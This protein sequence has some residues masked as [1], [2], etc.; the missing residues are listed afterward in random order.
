MNCSSSALD[1]PLAAVCML[2]QKSL[3]PTSWLAIFGAPLF[4]DLGSRMLLRDTM[5][6]RPEDGGPTERLKRIQKELGRADRDGDLHR[7]GEAVESVCLADI[8]G[9]R[10]GTSPI[11]NHLTTWQ[12]LTD[13]N[14]ILLSS[15]PFRTL[16]QELKRRRSSN[17]PLSQASAP[18][19]TICILDQ[20]KTGSIKS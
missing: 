2:R 10:S 8:P 1:R 11:R 16:G 6:D 5:V 20:A 4:L 15:L 14:V 17:V 13:G 3:K 7:L 9:F 12:T 18:L 19:Y